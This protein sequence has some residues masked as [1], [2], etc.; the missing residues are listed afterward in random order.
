MRKY[1]RNIIRHKAKKEKVKPSGYVKYMFNDIQIR[2]HGSECRSRNQARG[3][4]KRYLWPYRVALS[5]L[6]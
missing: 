1:I 4:H 6:K 5:T 2:K 3:T